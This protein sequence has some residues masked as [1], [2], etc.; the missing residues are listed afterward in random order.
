[1]TMSNII[2]IHQDVFELLEL[3]RLQNP[4]L[5]YKPR[6]R[7]NFDRLSKG[8][9]F[10][11][12]DKYLMVGFSEG[13]DQHEK[14]HN[15]GFVVLESEVSYLELSAQDNK[16]DAV[17]LENIATKLG[18][19]QMGKKNKWQKYYIDDDYKKSLH[20]FIVNDLPIINSAIFAS[21]N[22]TKIQPISEEDFQGYFN[23]VYSYMTSSNPSIEKVA[24]ICWNTN[25]WKSPS[26]KQGKSKNKNAYENEMGYGHEEWLF[27][28]SREINGYHYSFLQQ[29]NKTKVHLGQVY[30]IHLYTFN[31]SGT[32]CY[33]GKIKNVECITDDESK[34]ARLVY[35]KNNWFKEMSYEINAALGYK[36]LARFSTNFNIKF[37]LS[38]IEL[39]DELLEI[40]KTDPNTKASYYVLMNKKT[41]FI[42]SSVDENIQGKS[43]VKSTAKRN[44]TVNASLEFDPLHDK[45]QNKIVQLLKEDS[46]YDSQK[47][48]SEHNRVDIKAETTN[49]D[50]HFFE[51]KTANVKLSIRQA[52]GQL[53]EYTHYPN[54]NLAQKMYV[55]SYY[56]PTGEDIQYLEY[57]RELYKINVWYKYFDFSSNTLSIAEY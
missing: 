55:V 40:D 29:M 44:R 54:K 1:M 8:Y 25:G 37:K 19:H 13:G 30:T 38:D 35:R 31:T 11:G 33:I 36:A 43:N 39:E 28:P 4:N 12:D 51:L 26:G 18:M 53:L 16:D 41:D 14:V 42:F 23:N 50:W 15:I 47:V 9:W 20:Y 52:L 7:N 24:R 32:K 21:T 46:A 45:M 3:E 48:Y 10:I 6:Q 5:H 17:F 57:I 2:D 27:D 49:G 56:K 34:S 22:N